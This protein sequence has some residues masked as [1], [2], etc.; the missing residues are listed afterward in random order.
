MPDTLLNGIEVYYE[1][2][3]HGAPLLF[4][5]G[6]GSTI[7][8]VRPLVALFA[9]NFRVAVADYRGMGRTSVPEV[10]YSMTDLASDA[11]G[12]ADHLEWS[13]FN[14]LGVSFG[15]MVAHE[16]AV[17]APGRIRRLALVCTSSGGAGGSSYPLQDLV[18]LTPERRAEVSAHL[19][20]SRFTP[21]WLATR[22]KDRA[23]LEQAA[24]RRNQPLTVAAQRGAELQLLARASH[25]VFDRL[26][27]VASP[28]LVASGRFDGIAPPKNG[29]A[30]A[31][32]IPGAELRVYDGGHLFF[33]QDPA[34]IPDIVDFLGA[35]VR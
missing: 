33:Q 32:Q 11:I 10:P 13:A 25:D 35:D 22:A 28:T 21:E 7:A 18:H 29:A 31:E 5:N 23:I 26:P 1:T 4:L 14:L 3:G 30:I 20:D 24:Q 19:L 12:L 17:T 34:A 15:G 8:D 16:L 9:R 2:S 27:G 6:S